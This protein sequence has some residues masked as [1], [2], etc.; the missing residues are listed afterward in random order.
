MIGSAHDFFEAITLWAALVAYVGAGITAIVTLALGKKAERT[1]L[2]LL[3]L[4]L[5]LHTLTLGLRWDRLGHGPFITM[6]EILSSNIWSLTLVFTLAYWRYPSVRPIAA[7]VMPILFLMMGW[8][9]VTNPAEGHFPPTYRTV[10]LYIHIGFGKVF[11]GAVLVAVG[12]ASIVLARAAGLGVQR[13]A[14]LPSDAKLDDLSFRFMA[15]ALV[16]D[17]L[18]L[19]AGAIWAQ[20]AWGRYWDWDPLET[21]SLLT[22]LALVLAIHLRLVA[23]ATPRLSATLVLTVFTLAFLTFFG[24]PFVSTSPHKGAV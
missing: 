21:W 11:L 4:G 3:L 12:L 19:I 9:L 18:M 7:F 1:V 24:I 20:Q 13:L 2:A 14:W 5:A 23:K 10:W 6:F 15:L 16:F 17:T 8:L 22:W